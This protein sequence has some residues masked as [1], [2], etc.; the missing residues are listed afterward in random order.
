MTHLALPVQD[1]EANG[2]DLMDAVSL[3][4]L[5]QYMLGCRVQRRIRTVCLKGSGRLNFIR[6]GHESMS[7][8]WGFAWAH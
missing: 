3:A 8:E 6:S 1:A 5:R 2:G 4:V 7:E